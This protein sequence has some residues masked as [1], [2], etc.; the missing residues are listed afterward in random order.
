MGVTEEKFDEKF[1]FN[2]I[3]HRSHSNGIKM[4]KSLAEVI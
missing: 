3:Q 4:I 1:K 2:S